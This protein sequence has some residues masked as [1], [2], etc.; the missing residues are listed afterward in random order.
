MTATGFTSSLRP[1]TTARILYVNG[2]GETSERTI[3][4]IRRSTARN[5]YTYVRAYCHL[6]GEERTFRGDRVL[7]VLERTADT[8][9]R[10]PSPQPGTLRATARDQGTATRTQKPP[11]PHQPT[12]PCAMATAGRREPAVQRPVSRTGHR[13]KR[14]V[15]RLAF[16]ALVAIVGARLLCQQRAAERYGVP[17]ETPLPVVESVAAPAELAEPVGTPTVRTAAATVKPSPAPDFVRAESYRGQQVR[18]ER[19]AGRITY[20]LVASGKSFASAQEMRVLVNTTFFRK[21]T[22]FDDPELIALYIAADHDAN[23]EVSWDEV[24]R[25]QSLLD[26]DFEYLHNH[27]A[28][29]PTEFMSAGGGDCED[30]A[31]MTA[32]ML[33]FWGAPVYVGSLTSSEGRH[34]VALVRTDDVPQYS[35]P[36][37]IETGG[38]LPPGRY[39][40]IDYD[41]VGTLSNAVA[42]TYT[43]NWIRVPEELFGLAM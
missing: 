31:L 38:Y 1:G 3:D 11:T 42:G 7:A 36:I 23:G 6:R 29:R 39:V 26:R 17:R 30:W 24:R 35:H 43:V 15:L 21:H 12:A 19:A 4:V 5:G 28:L 9:R 40:P 33:R 34:A 13:R 41:H 16:V 18:V 14:S 2:Y 22:G 25:F 8:Q 10:P 37:D 20:T 32:G 27:K